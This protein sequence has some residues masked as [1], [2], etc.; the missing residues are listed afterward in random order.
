MDYIALKNEITNDPLDFGY[1]EG[2]ATGSLHAPVACHARMCVVD[3][4]AW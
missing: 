2:P 3:V 1:A 4:P